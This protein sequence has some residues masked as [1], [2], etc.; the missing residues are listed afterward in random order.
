MEKKIRTMLFL[1]ILLFPTAV[2]AQEGPALSTVGVKLWPEYDRSSM[3]VI[4][5]ITLSPQVALPFQMSMRIPLAVGSLHAVAVRQ[6]G[7]DLVNIPYEQE[8]E[9]G[10]TRVVFQATTPEIRLEYYDP[11]LG[12]EDSHRRYK[13]SW[14]GD[15]TVGSFNVEVQQ[16]TGA[17]ELQIKP[18]M[19]NARQGSDGLTYY[20]MNVGPLSAGQVFEITVEY[21]KESDVLSVSD[22]PVEP[23]APLDGSTPGR[24]SGRSIL[25]LLLGILGLLLLVGGGVWYW[26]SG[27]QRIKPRA[28]G[29]VRR[30]SEKPSEAIETQASHIYCPQC[31]KRATPGDRF[32]RAC[33]TELRIS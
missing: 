20:L 31:G 15:F 6:P 30:P 32:C 16:P 5:D 3:L 4:Y 10:W 12:I 14:P 28:K 27:R 25:P 8:S 18:G 13:Y 9:T 2:L 29:R 1:L 19:V 7:G 11:G 26:Q 22:M 21:D 33:G 24:A 23:S 17:S